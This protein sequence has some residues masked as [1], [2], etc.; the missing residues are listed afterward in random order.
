MAKISQDESLKVLSKAPSISK[1][2]ARA[3]LKNSIDN[4]TEVFG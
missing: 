2:E 1:F 3:S 4:T